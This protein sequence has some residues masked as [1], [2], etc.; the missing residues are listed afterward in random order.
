MSSYP[1]PF[2]GEVSIEVKGESNAQFGLEIFALNGRSIQS[3]SNLVFNTTYRFGSQWTQGVYVLKA[4]VNG[5]VI[6]RKVVKM[7]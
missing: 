1:N 5:K 2:Q 6:T 4:N 3:A 7:N